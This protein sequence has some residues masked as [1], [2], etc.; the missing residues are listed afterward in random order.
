MN[1]NIAMQRHLG[2][3]SRLVGHDVSRKY[4]YIIDQDDLTNA[5]LQMRN[6]LGYPLMMDSK[7]RRA[8]VYNKEG[9]ERRITETINDCIMSN[10]KNIEDMI[11]EDIGNDIVNMMNGLTQ[12]SNGTI[13]LGSKHSSSVIG[14]FTNI[15]A[16]GLVKG[17]GNVIDDLIY[18]RDN[19]R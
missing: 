14:K 3:L 15:L 5:Y 18:P 9:L 8:I 12:A 19:K 16:K 4:N 1:Y 2:N 10:I 17:I 7:Y 11:A 13:I 6:D